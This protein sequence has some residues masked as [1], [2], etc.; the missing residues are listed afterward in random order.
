MRRRTAAWPET[1]PT[2]GVTPLLRDEDVIALRDAARA[3]LDPP[4]A[5]TETA[6]PLPERLRAMGGGK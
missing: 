5:D 3:A 1:T 6:E 2:L 4:A